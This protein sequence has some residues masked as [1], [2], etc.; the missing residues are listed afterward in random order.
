MPIA[1]PRSCCGKVLI[2]SEP[3]GGIIRAAPTPWRARE[4]MIM[5]SSVARPVAAEPTAKMITPIW[6]MRT[7][8]NM[9]EKR[10]PTATSEA[11]ASR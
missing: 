8:L 4:P 2:T 7:A 6:N 10:P 11:I 1:L 5:A 9:V 3:E